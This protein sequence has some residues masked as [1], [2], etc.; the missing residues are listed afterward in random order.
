[1]KQRKLKYIILF[2]VFVCIPLHGQENYSKLTEE[3]LEAMW[4]AKD[5][6]GYKKSLDMYEHAFFSF[7]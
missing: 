6:V 2:Y 1:M 5:A 4:Q 3:A 7:S